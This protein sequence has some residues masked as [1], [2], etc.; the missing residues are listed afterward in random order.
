MLA[1]VALLASLV[2]VT[3]GFGSGAPTMACT[4]M[5]PQHSPHSWQ[6]VSAPFQLTTDSHTY[7][8][9]APLRVTI[10]GS[11]GFRG[12]MLQARSPFYTGTNAVG[13]V[14]AF[15]DL[16][17]SARTESCFSTGDTATHL[18]G[19]DVKDSVT[20]TWVP[21]ANLRG[22]VALTATIV[23]EFS[24]FWVGVSTT[25]HQGANHLITG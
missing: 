19:H 14:G 12:F 16:P 22:P 11:R 5:T 4:G 1:Y 21:P 7:T 9:G 23:A 17:A 8:P 3:H 10:R 24:T 15:Q 25:V 13:A 6:T 2:A 20:V 18:T